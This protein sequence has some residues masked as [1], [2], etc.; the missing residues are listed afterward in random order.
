MGTRLHVRAAS[1][2]V[3]LVEVGC[4]AVRGGPTVGRGPSETPA[5]GSED[6]GLDRARRSLCPDLSPGPFPL[7]LLPRSASRTPT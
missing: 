7:P 4:A 2:D 3:N 5:A 6:R 1:N